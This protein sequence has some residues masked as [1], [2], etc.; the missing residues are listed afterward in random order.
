MNSNYKS[1]SANIE[2]FIKKYHKNTLLKGFIYLLALVI[3]AFLVF[4]FI[5]YFFSLGVIGRS[6]LFYL[7]ITIFG[8]NLIFWIF[9]PLLKL[10]RVIKSIDNEEAAIL[11]GN[12]FPEI[13]D[14][15]INTIQLNE[16]GKSSTTENE[17][18]AASISQKVSNLSLFKF[19]KAIDFGVNRKYLKYV[20]PPVLLTLII[21]L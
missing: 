12:F 19:S 11:I 13:G 7:F 20:L 18:I 6:F 8:F 2:S 3:T 16:M 17:L 4:I 15:L 1:L 5:E 9:I 14:K 10:T 21:L